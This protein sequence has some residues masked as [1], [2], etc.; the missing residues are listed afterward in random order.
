MTTRTSILA[1]LCA[2]ALATGCE[3]NAV[4]DIT[5]PSPGEARVKFFNFGVS[6]PGVNFYANDKKMTAITS[7]TGVESTN[8]VAY[9]SAGSGGLYM[10]LDPGQYTLA[11]KIA[12]TTDKDLAISGV[13]ATLEAG[14]Y[15]SFYQ[16]GLYNTTTK[17]SDAFVVE[18]PFLADFDYTAAY[19]RFVNSI[20][21][22]NP[23]TLYA[24]NTVTSAEVAVGGSM[25]YKAAGAFVAVPNGIYDLGARYAGVTTNAISRTAVSFSAGRV[26]TITARG[27]ILTSSTLFLDNTTNR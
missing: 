14:K 22:A 10:A 24:K 20:Y 18:D 23:M 9:G 15:Y 3:E 27:D 4:Q 26:Y 8:G 7:A 5:E 17:K 6:S 1:L 13:T 11:G 25:A 21:N 19:V 12:A 16:S 2:A